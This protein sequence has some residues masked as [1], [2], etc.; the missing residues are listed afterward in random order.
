MTLLPKELLEKI[1]PLYATEDQSN[2]MVHAKFFT[3]DAAWSWYV[4]EY[5]PK[6]RLC[7]GL[8]QGLELEL[9]YF[10]LKEL[11]ELSG[12]LGLRVERDIS[13]Q[14]LKLQ[15]LREQLAW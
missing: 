2:P 13:F 8:V 10:S 9:G 7:F 4:T 5:D 3:P 15:E 1:P 12:P 6:K 14:P 11:E